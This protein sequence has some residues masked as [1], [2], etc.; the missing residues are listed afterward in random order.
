MSELNRAGHLVKDKVGNTFKRALLIIACSSGGG[1]GG[2][3]VAARVCCGGVLI[4]VDGVWK[5]LAM[6][7]QLKLK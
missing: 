7:L 3:G 5:R 1:V 4:A 2:G 6:K